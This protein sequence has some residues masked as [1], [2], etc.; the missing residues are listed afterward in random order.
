MIIVH[1]NA[2]YEVKCWTFKKIRT[3]ILWNSHKWK[4]T[5]SQIHIHWPERYVHVS[6]HVFYTYM[7]F[8]IVHAMVSLYREL[9]NSRNLMSWKY[10]SMQS[11]I[12]RTL[13]KSDLNDGLL[14]LPSRYIFNQGVFIWNCACVLDGF[15]TSYRHRV[16]V[17]SLNVGV[18]D[19]PFFKK[20]VFHLCSLQNE[21]KDIFYIH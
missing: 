21:C 9:Y 19:E 18:C 1:Y 10:T 17:W 13:C 7:H 15:N 3:T 6:T 4:V 14:C 5:L 11:G 20:S 8:C 12:C 2:L 16:L